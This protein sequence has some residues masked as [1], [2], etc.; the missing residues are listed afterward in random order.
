MEMKTDSIERILGSL[1]GLQKAG[2]PDLFYTRLMG[3]M[4]QEP[5]RKQVWILK[6]AFITT[7][8]GVLL[9]LN[10][11]SFMEIRSAGSKQESRSR[12]EQPAGIESFARAYNM[13]TQSLYE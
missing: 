2:A 13:N 4:Q 8:L 11:F 7:A 9:L 5:E 10:I 6:P 1:D 12:H 3:R